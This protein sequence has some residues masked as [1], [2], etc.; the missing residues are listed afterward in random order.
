VRTLLDSDLAFWRAALRE[1]DLLVHK[2]TIASFIAIHFAW[3]NVVLT[4]LPSDAVGAAIPPSWEVPFDES[5]RSLRRA[6]AG[7]L[8]LAK[9]AVTSLKETG[10]LF[11]VPA[12]DRQPIS[13]A[14][15]LNHR[16]MLPLLQPQDYLNKRAVELE[17]FAAASEAPL[18]ELAARLA[19]AQRDAAA[20]RGGLHAYNFF[21]SLLLAA[22]G[23]DFARLASRVADLEGVRRAA[24]LAAAVRSRDASAQ[25]IVAT[26]LL[27]NP[28]NGEPF[29]VDSGARQIVFLGRE[30]T[31]RGR[32][33]FLW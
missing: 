23:A 2:M 28:Y 20:A 5:E 14:Q 3:G 22:E 27:R 4:R 18:T 17:A 13:L 33:A 21:G 16:M 24:L 12:A 29:S 15:R 9:N 25:S 19:I 26:D 8:M 31:V 1:S 30:S 7:E 11:P 10:Y 32:H 6:N